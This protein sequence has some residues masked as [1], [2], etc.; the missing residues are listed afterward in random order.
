MEDQ[1]I[2]ILNVVGNQFF[3]VSTV[4]IC[5]LKIIPTNVARFTVSRVTFY[6]SKDQ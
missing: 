3:S 2:R 6:T 1:P 5:S 4:K